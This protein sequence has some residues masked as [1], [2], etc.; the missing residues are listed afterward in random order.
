MP[1]VTMLDCTTLDPPCP[2]TNPYDTHV[3]G[4]A[5]MHSVMVV[6]MAS[7]IYDAATDQSVYTLTDTAPPTQVQFNAGY[8]TS[9]VVTVQ[10]QFMAGAD[11]TGYVPMQAVNADHT[12]DSLT[13]FNN[14]PEALG[15]QPPPALSAQSVIAPV[16]S[17][18]NGDITAGIVVD[19]YDT[20]AASGSRIPL[21][22]LL[23]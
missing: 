8:T 21:R 6:T 3:S 16:G 5:T 2:S 18:A 12:A 13:L 22:C 19:T 15:S 9:G 4:Y 23:G 11:S 1:P 10:T 7:P 20:V 17:T 14:T